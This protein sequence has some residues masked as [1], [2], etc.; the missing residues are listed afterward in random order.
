MSKNIA[1][2]GLLLALNIVFLILSF[3]IPTNTLFFM[4]LAS[5]PIAIVIIEQGIKYGIVF[6]VASSI[7]SFL[8]IPD[9]I[10][11]IFYTFTFG[12]Y[13]V[14]KYFIERDRN[15]FIEYILK[16][17]IFN[18]IIFLGYFFIKNFIYIPLNP[19]TILVAQLIFIAYDYS[20]GIFID[21]YYN[22]I[23]KNIKFINK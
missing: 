11:W 12:I 22:K 21:Y 17:G 23:R 13:G 19:I 6:Y 9:K 2:S 20:Y 7:L 8:F 3:I 18:I 16:L 10:N 15:I 1:Y 4:G 5:L 14:I